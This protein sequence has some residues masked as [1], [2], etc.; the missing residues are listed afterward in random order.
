M[1][2]EILHIA[3]QLKDAFEGEPWYGRSVTELLKEVNEDIVFEKPSGQHSILELVWHMVNWRAF[4]IACLTKE[5]AKPGSYFEEND[6]RVLDHAD[7]AL[8]QEGLQQLFG[9]QEK[10]IQLLQGLQDSILEDTVP[11]RNYNFRKL[12]YGIVQHDVYH[13]GQ[14]AY[15]TKMAH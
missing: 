5:D 15:L 6:W 11:H 13:I 10:L 12:L 9:T 7:R 4:T 14:I 3:G 8:W 1:N 2:Y